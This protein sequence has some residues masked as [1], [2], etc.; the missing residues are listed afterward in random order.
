MKSGEK[1]HKSLVSKGVFPHRWAFTLLCP[2]RNILLSPK[3]LADRLEVKEHFHILEVGPGPGYFSVF[4]ARKLTSGR[5]TLVDIQP[6]ML[7]IAK[8]RLKGRGLTN[9][10]YYICD[11]ERF[12]LPMDQFEVIFLVT[13][14]GEVE[15]KDNYLREFYRLLKPD[16]V[17]SFS[18]QAG[19]PD[20]LSMQEVRT[21][22]EGAGFIF[23]KQFGSE[24]NYTINFRK[25]C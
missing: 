16:G 8:K 1:V 25:V 12:D 17:L 15:N 9:V 6:E 19:D 18:E 21:L 10:D 4:I 2:L 7:D 3:R 13:V 23:D 22:V 11:G 24:W 14:I 20:K 5:L